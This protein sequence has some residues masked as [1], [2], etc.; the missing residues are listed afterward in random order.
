MEFRVRR[1]DAFRQF[2]LDVYVDVF[3]RRGELE[4]AGVDLG[5][6]FTQ[7]ALDG[8]E[9]VFGQ[10][11]GGLCPRVVDWAFSAASVL[12]KSLSSS[13]PQARKQRLVPGPML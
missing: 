13:K 9:F 4:I 12:E 3:E 2:R 5:L 10:Q 6:D 8:G 11:F 1:A 7:I